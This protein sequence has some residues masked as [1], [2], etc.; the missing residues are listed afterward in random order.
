MLGLFAR[1]VGNLIVIALVVV[2]ADTV[3]Q[4]IGVWKRSYD[5]EGQNLRTVS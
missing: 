1:L 5:K 3:L 2:G 4:N